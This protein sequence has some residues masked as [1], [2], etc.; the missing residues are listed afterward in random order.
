LGKRP[1][2]RKLATRG[3]KKVG[4]GRGEFLAYYSTRRKR[5]GRDRWERKEIMPIGSGSGKAPEGATLKGPQRKGKKKNN[6]DVGRKEMGPVKKCRIAPKK[7]RK[8]RGDRP[9]KR[10]RKKPLGHS[11]RKKKEPIFKNIKP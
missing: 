10:K 9:L 2:F 8:K 4:A 1:I 7:G 6:N 11:E 3:K 5:R